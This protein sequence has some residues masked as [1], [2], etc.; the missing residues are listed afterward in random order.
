MDG[1]RGGFSRISN[2]RF[3]TNV[4]VVELLNRIW[5]YKMPTQA[6]FEEMI[7]NIAMQQADPPPMQLPASYLLIVTDQHFIEIWRNGSGYNFAPTGRKIYNKIQER[8]K[9]LNLI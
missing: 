8:A 4:G 5:Y 9:K 7:N 6:E 3:D 1:L 2:T